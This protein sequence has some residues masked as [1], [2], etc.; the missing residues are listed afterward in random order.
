[1]RAAIAQLKRRLPE[2]V[3]VHDW[4]AALVVTAFGRV[5]HDAEALILYRQHGRNTYGAD[6]GRWRFLKRHLRRFVKGPRTFYQGHAQAAELLN[7]Y[8]VD[9]A[10]AKKELLQ[11]FVA[12]KR[13]IM[14]RLS[15]A[16]RGPIWRA[17]LVDSLA[18]RLLIV[19]GWY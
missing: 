8:G 18:L 15:Y 5:V 9:L 17:R 1:N 7:Q 19:L 3:R 2:R 6:V 4:W 13:H 10:P 14:T 12:S 11:G 16:A